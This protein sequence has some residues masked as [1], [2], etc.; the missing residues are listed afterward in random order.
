MSSFVVI[1]KQCRYKNLYY[2]QLFCLCTGLAF[3]LVSYVDHFR[4]ALT[5]DTSVVSKEDLRKLTK[6]VEKYIEAQHQ[7][8]CIGV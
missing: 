2:C 5:G 1:R 8:V 3:L 6:L 7:L 4:V